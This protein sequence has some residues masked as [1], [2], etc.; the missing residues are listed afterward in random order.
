MDKT[1]KFP[2]IDGLITERFGTRGKFAAALGVTLT[3]LGRKMN[4]K[5]RWKTTEIV[6]ACKLLGLNTDDIA[7]YFFT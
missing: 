1:C 5:S 7:S 6:L 2:K 4:G 3:T